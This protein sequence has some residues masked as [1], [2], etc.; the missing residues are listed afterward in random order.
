M[1]PL[2]VTAQTTLVIDGF[3][4][5]ANSYVFYA[6]RR[7]A[8]PEV[9]LA[10]HTHSART[11]LTAAHRGIPTILLIRSPRDAVSSLVQYAPGVR[12]RDGFSAYTRFHEA[13]GEVLG[14]IE[15]APFE[16]VTADLSSVLART[17]RRYGVDL[18]VYAG[19]AQDEQA[20]RKA[21]DD[22]NRRYHGGSENTAA[23][24]SPA[25]RS[26]A[27]ILGDLD[28]RTKSALRRAETAY[29]LV[30]SAR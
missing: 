1:R 19:G 15:I 10:G 27:E 25:R 23:R 14:Q 6:V 29:Q 26:P 21:L 18:P 8:G 28:M 9:H 20:V 5:S 2:R 17:G 30:I 13:L 4:R 12:P 24:P 11:I 3:P 7:V 22:A 16:E